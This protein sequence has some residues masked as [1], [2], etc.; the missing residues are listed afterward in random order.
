MNTGIAV[1]TTRFPTIR[2]RNCQQIVGEN[3]MGDD[4]I[5]KDLVGIELLATQEAS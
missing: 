2:I 4:E 3:G 1:V 5:G